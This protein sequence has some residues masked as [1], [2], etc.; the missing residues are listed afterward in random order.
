MVLLHY[1]KS[2][3]QCSC[4]SV[5]TVTIRLGIRPLLSLLETLYYF[6]LLLLLESTIRAAVYNFT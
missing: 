4:G 2:I 3:K 6:K 1:S 5:S